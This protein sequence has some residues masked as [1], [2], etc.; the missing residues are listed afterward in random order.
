MAEMARSK[1][2]KQHREVHGDMVVL[3]KVESE[4]KQVVSLC[5]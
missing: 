2:R 5:G 3:N 4:K 1:C